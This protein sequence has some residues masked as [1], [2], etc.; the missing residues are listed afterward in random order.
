MKII[1]RNYTICDITERE[2][3]TI[4]KALIKHTSKSES[5]TERSISED[6]I[7]KTEVARDED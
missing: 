7:W 5:D 2:L 1:K 6:L 4:Q 3:M